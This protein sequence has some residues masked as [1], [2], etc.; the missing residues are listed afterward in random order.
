MKE[1]LRINWFSPLA[2]AQTDIAHYTARI[3]PALAKRAVV[4]LWTDQ[5]E[6]DKGLA[7]YAEVK[8][9][10]LR[11]MSWAEINRAGIS[12][13]QIGNNPLFHGNIW[14]VSRQLGGVVVLHDFRLHHFFDGLY[15]PHGDLTGYLKAMTRYYGSESRNDAVNSFRTN[16][17]NI[18]YMAERYPLTEHALEN[19]IGVVVHTDEAFAELSSRTEAPLAMIPLPFPAQPLKRSSP[20]Q[21]K[22]KRLILFGYIGRNRRLS[23]VLKALAGL[24]EKQQFHLDIF[25][26]ILDDEREVKGLISTLGLK[27]QVT[28]HGFTAEKDLDAALARADLA[29]NLRFP[30]MGEA[31]GSQLR[32]WSHA[33]PSLVSQIGWYASLPEEAVAHVRT[34]EQEIGDIQRHLR[35]FLSHQELFAQMGL[36]GRQ[37]LEL[38]HSPDHY[39]ES[40]L[41]LAEKACFHRPLAAGLALAERAANETKL[42]QASREAQD[43]LFA[44]VAGEI[45]RLAES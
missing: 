43:K 45:S 16:A 24:A 37:E 11:K 25:G 2:P 3:L 30:T 14:Q 22:T 44:R 38:K 10:H 32:I 41:A 7:T 26:S 9:Y 36:R 12:F 31:S 5:P 42:W 23:S 17:R 4:T 33:L 15:R 6:W 28:L 8:R 29:I 27:P 34:G 1:P 18:D 39:V 13:F 19:A 40:L 20:A 21:E 35:N